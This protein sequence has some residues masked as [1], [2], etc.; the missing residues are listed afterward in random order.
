MNPGMFGCETS[1]GCILR[2]VGK[3]RSISRPR[4]QEPCTWDGLVAPLWHVRSSN[5]ALDEC[6]P[7]IRTCSSLCQR[8]GKGCPCHACAKC[9]NSVCHPSTN[10]NPQLA[11]QFIADGKAW[12]LKGT[13]IWFVRLASVIWARFVLNSLGKVKKRAS[14]PLGNGETRTPEPD[15]FSALIWNASVWR[16]SGSR[17]LAEHALLVYL[18][19]NQ[20]FCQWMFFCL[21]CSICRMYCL[22]LNNSQSFKLFLKIKNQS[23]HLS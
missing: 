20:R 6:S 15:A 18:T 13:G 4:L 14:F 19:E 9:A 1:I 11:H 10:I 7:W 23:M 5:A 8:P 22:P 21:L 16:Q 3:E 12:C 2:W 17:Y